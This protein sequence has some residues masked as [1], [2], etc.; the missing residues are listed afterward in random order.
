MSETD[1][2]GRV[3]MP[4]T[5]RSLHRDLAALGVAPGMVLICHSSL[6]SLG[7]VCGG[8]VAVIQALETA[9]GGPRTGTLVMPPISAEL[10]EPS[11]WSQPPVP[12]A[13]WQ[14][15]RDEMPPFAPD[16]TPVRGTGQIT[17]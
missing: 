5:V 1:A 16:L 11:L 2:I 3:A 13:W 6:A 12:P 4:A 17:E 15:I 7:W 9:L 14:P 8:A 10:S